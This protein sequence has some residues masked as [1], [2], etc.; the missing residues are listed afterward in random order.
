MNSYIH[1][2]IQQR[3]DVRSLTI[4]HWLHHELFSLIWWIWLAASIVALIVAWVFV[5]RKRILEISVFGL[6]INVFSNF[7]DIGGSEYVLWVY[8]IQLL[9]NTTVMYPVDYFLLPMLFMLI[10]QRYSTW[11]SFLI[12]CA[13]ASAVL[14]FVLEPLVV[15]AGGY[16]LV[17]WH[18]IYSFPIYIGLV[19]SAKALTQLILARQNSE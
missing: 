8:P 14:S 16:V 4:E 2:L 15:W 12:A 17:K 7:L 13:I 3:L 5:D 9:P 6:I 11:K 10:Y 18:Y 19:A 1:Q